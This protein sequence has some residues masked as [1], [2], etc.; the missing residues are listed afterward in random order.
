MH[1]KINTK[2]GNEDAPNNHLQPNNGI[3][4]TAKT[5]SKQAPI[6]QNII[7]KLTHLALCFNG[8]NSLYNVIA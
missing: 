7:L 2:S 3:I 6:D 5:T 1:R 8:K 4:R